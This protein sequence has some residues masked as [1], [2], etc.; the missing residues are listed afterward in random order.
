VAEESPVVLVVDDHPELCRMVRFAFE[1]DGFRVYEAADGR[2]A[3]DL[4]QAVRPSVII[5]DV[6]MPRMDGWAF[7]AAQLDL[8]AVRDVPV[9]LFTGGGPPE[10]P[11]PELAPAAVVAKAA[12]VNRLLAA[13]KS[14]LDPA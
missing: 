12:G 8:P 14:V 3:L 11:V 1:R 2:A 9:V 7:R 13:V 5:L 4:L 6:A 10:P